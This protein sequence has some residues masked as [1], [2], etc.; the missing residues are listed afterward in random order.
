MS[1][2]AARQRTK[3]IIGLINDQLKLCVYTHTEKQF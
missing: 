1:G 3:V 2:T